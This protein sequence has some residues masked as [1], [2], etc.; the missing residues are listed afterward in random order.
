MRFGRC[1]ECNDFKY[2]VGKCLCEEHYKEKFEMIDV[3]VSYQEN[4]AT[5]I[6]IKAI[7]DVL[8]D[9]HQIEDNPSDYSYI[10]KMTAGFVLV[11][12]STGH[13]KNRFKY[14]DN[15]GSSKEKM[16]KSVESAVEWIIDKY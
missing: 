7:A 11:K 13:P 12:D 6:G 10:I 2:L 4:M 15:S 8:H 5:P 16:K 1:K 14:S 9:Y 3:I